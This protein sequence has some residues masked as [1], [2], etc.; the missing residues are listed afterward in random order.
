[1]RLQ[2]TFLLAGES[3]GMPVTP[4]LRQPSLV[5]KH[6]LIEGG[7]GIHF[8]NNFTTGGD[9]IIQPAYHNS[10]WLTALLP[11]RAPL[12]T[13]RVITASNRWLLHS[14]RGERG[15]HRSGGDGTPRAK[16]AANGDVAVGGAARN[17]D[18]GAGG[19]ASDDDVGV[20]GVASGDDDDVGVGGAASDDGVMGLVENACLGPV[21]PDVVVMTAVLRAGR[22]GALTDHNS[23]CYNVDLLTGRLQQGVS[24]QHW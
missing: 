2:G 15:A 9:W 4:F 14:Q 13:F 20:G 7:L 10:T 17:G 21:A 19:V 16:G 1:M 6:K 24:N 18:V 23:V 22:S 12:S 8:F 5:L 3:A 11:P